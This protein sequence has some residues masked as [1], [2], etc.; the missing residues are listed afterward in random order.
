MNNEMHDYKLIII[1]YSYQHL[2]CDNSCYVIL[3][4]QCLYIVVI[5]MNYYIIAE[6][7]SS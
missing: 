7:L 6:F 2:Q 4:S 5:C 1:K 3:P